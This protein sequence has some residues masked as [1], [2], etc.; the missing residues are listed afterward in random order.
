MPKKKK[1]GVCKAK[2]DPRIPMALTDVDIIEKVREASLKQIAVRWF[3]MLKQHRER[4]ILTETMRVAYEEYMQM[5]NESLVRERIDLAVCTTFRALAKEPLTI[6]NEPLSTIIAFVGDGLDINPMTAP[7]ARAMATLRSVWESYEARVVSH[8]NEAEQVRLVDRVMVEV[9]AWWNKNG[10]H[11]VSEAFVKR[12][13]NKSVDI[14]MSEA[15]FPRMFK[16]MDEVLWRSYLDDDLHEQPTVQ[17]DEAKL[18]KRL[19]AFFQ[20][21]PRGFHFGPPSL[22][23]A[24]SDGQIAGQQVS[25]SSVV[26]PKKMHKPFSLCTLSN[27]DLAQLMLPWN[28]KARDMRHPHEKAKMMLCSQD[29]CMTLH[30]KLLLNS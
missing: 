10:G 28:W 4:W 13:G 15:A 2:P 24:R 19:Q 3:D 14:A 27:D 17:C 6:P 25:P 12:P 21:E 26:L 18:M 7:L 20:E 30:L 16:T 11:L 8:W 9:A 29:E 1:A 5:V 23:K 22:S